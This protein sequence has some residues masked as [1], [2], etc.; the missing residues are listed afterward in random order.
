MECGEGNASRASKKRNCGVAVC[1]YV[2]GGGGYTHFV[3]KD[4]AEKRIEWD[5]EENERTIDRSIERTNERKPGESRNER[6]DLG[7]AHSF[8]TLTGALL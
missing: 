5:E 7:P 6:R 4:E 1:Q 3:T 2:R 8:W